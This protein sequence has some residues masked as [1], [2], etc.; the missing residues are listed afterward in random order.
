MRRS[1]HDADDAAG[2]QTPS[3]DMFDRVLRQP[4]FR[5]SVDAG[6]LSQ[7]VIDPRI[8]SQSPALEPGKPHAFFGKSLEMSYV[9]HDCLPDQN[10]GSGRHVP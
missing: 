10:T 4:D 2:I 7:R 6:P 3:A 9:P 8:L 1:D 5:R